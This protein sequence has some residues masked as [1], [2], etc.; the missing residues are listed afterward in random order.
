MA[1]NFFLIIHNVV[2]IAS[3][4]VFSGAALFAFLSGPKRVANVTFSLT[5]VA[6]NVF[7]I[8]H[9]IGVN[10]VDPGL[11]K[12][13]L[14]FNLS[15]LFIGAF[16]LHAVLAMIGKD[17]EKSWIIIFTYTLGIILTVL[18]SLYPDL[19]LLP[20]VPK[21]Y[22]PNYYNPGSLNIIRIV[23]LYIF[24]VPYAIYQLYI[25]YRESEI[26]IKRKQYK[27]FMGAATAGFAVGLISNFLVYDIQI[28]PLWGM[29]FGIFFIVPFTYG[30]IRYEIFDIRVIAK[31]A[32]YYSIFVV[33]IGGLITL[34][35]YS[36]NL[37][38]A[39]YPLF[40]DW[41]M[42][43]A[44]AILVVTVGVVIWWQL[45]RS[46]LLK[47]EFFS[48]IIHKFRTP[49]TQIKWSV[50]ELEG[51]EID[52]N[53][54]QSLRYIKSFNQKMIDLTGTLVELSNSKSS[55]TI[56]G[57]FEKVSL[58]DLLKNVTDSYKDMFSKKQ[59]TLSINCPVKD[60]MV[61]IDK[62]RIKFV[63]QT[64]LENAVSYTPPH[65]KVSVVIETSSN[66]VSISI[67][68]TGIG[69]SKNDINSLFTGFYRT[70]KA[71]VAD[72]E[73]FGIGLYLSQAIARRYNGDIKVY[74]EGEGKGSTFKFTLQKV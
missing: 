27:Y 30:A 62:E 26:D 22:F 9:V 19:F 69:I 74:S 25:A 54:L 17:H 53:K 50:E 63:I 51:V 44:S 39:V 61:K 59:I 13:A 20:S 52:Q 73:G 21:M 18:F 60:V 36:N 38:M 45:R 31:Q 10:I 35:N 5:L 34:I 41:I 2:S 43:L 64:L 7:I 12:A 23:Y 14:M 1:P 70:G 49:L 71:K 72:T 33:I 37:L 55:K 40:P 47:Y 15:I 67:T 32:F 3:F 24:V 4:I 48:I 68:D 42:T 11:S 8:S 6:V 46:D 28:D 56:F 58:C 65:G 57:R 29:L 66:N 16:F